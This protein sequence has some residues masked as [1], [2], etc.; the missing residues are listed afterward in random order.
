MKSRSLFI[1]GLVCGG[2]ALVALVVGL[3]FFWTDN[4]W[5]DDGCFGTSGR[6]GMMGGLGGMMGPDGIMG[7]N[8]MMGPGGMMGPGRQP[9]IQGPPT[10]DTPI[11]A[12]Q[13]LTMAQQFL[14]GFLPG[15]KTGDVDVF[16]SFRTID[17][18]RDGRKQGMLSVNGYTG[19]VWYH[20]WHGD[21]LE[22]WQRQP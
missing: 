14:D 13:A 20:T 18:N 10:A 12:D 16:Y 8:N 11:T 19:A 3:G 21:F 17:V 22:S 4:G 15:T 2:V 7:G 6:E 9:G 5:D 1:W